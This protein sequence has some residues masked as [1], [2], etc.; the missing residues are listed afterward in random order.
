M[1]A[2]KKI[3]QAAIIIEDLFSK[4]ISRF[5]LDYEDPRIKLILND[6]VIVYLQYN[7]HDQYSYNIIFSNETLDR[8]R[9]DNYDDKWQVECKPHHFHPRLL[10]EAFFSPMSGNPTKDLEILFSLLISGKMFNQ[11]F[12][13]K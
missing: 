12:S 3:K 7:N 6:G 13:F 9:F 10:K 4:Q 1:K 11:N 2:I 8:C 5:V